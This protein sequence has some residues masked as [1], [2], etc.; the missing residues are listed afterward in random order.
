MISAFLHKLP[1]SVIGVVTRPFFVFV[2][3][4]GAEHLSA[5]SSNGGHLAERPLEE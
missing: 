2:M 3:S 1:P 5:Q 4:V